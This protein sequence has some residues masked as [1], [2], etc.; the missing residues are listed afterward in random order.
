MHREGRFRSTSRDC[1]SGEVSLNSCLFRKHFPPHRLCLDVGCSITLWHVGS[2]SASKEEPSEVRSSGKQAESVSSSCENPQGLGINL[3]P[4]GPDLQPAGAPCAE[5]LQD[6][7]PL[8]VLGTPG[9][10]AWLLIVCWGVLYLACLPARGVNE[11][12]LRCS[13]L[14]PRERAEALEAMYGRAYMGRVL[15]LWPWPNISWDIYILPA[16]IGR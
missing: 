15:A 4:T 7:H 5:G 6:L 3:T 14:A 10:R 8:R 11:R 12:R 16:C 2:S 1:S 13:S 9:L